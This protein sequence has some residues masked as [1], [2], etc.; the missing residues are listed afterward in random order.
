MFL[1]MCGY[2]HKSAVSMKSRESV[3]SYGAGIACSSGPSD[4]V[5]GTELGSFTRAARTFNC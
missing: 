4:M 1:P 3:G 5:L 2:V